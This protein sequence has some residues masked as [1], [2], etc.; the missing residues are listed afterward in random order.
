[1]LRFL[2]CFKE[3]QKLQAKGIAV[4]ISNQLANSVATRVACLTILLVMVIPLFDVMSFPQNDYSLQTWVMRLSISHKR[5]N[6]EKF[7]FEINQMV[8]FFKDDNYGPYSA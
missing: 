4:V 2:P 8:E 5:K 1:M 3:Q 6:A 7:Q